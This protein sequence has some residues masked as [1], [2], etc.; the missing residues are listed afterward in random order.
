MYMVGFDQGRHNASLWSI[1]C[2]TEV[3]HIVPGIK[4]RRFTPLKQMP[5]AGPDIKLVLS[6]LQH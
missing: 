1:H 5:A 2:S 4:T 3:I 6:N